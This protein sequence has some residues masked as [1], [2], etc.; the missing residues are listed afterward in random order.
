MARL[1]RKHIVASGEEGFYHVVNRVAGFP[2]YLPFKR[3]RVR[4]TLL[5]RLIKCLKIYCIDCFA[6]TIMGNHFHIVLRVNEF[7]KLTRRELER[8]ACE[9]WGDK[10][11]EVKTRHWDD[12]RWLRFNRDLFD[13]GSFM[14]HLESPFVAWYNKAFGREG[15]MWKSRY[16]SLHLKDLDA[17][18]ECL[19][20]VELN[21]VRAHL[22][23]RP[24]HWKE[25]SAVMRMNGEDELLIPLREVFPELPE[26]EPVLPHYRA[27]MLYRGLTTPKEGQGFIEEE[28]IRMEEARNFVDP[29]AYLTKL[30]FMTHGLVLGSSDQ[31]ANRLE[32]LLRLGVYK[33]KRNPPRQLRGRL[34]TLREQRS[35]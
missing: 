24:E 33:R 20:Y 32:R 25:G 26:N 30:R 28:I 21:P 9:R 6:F 18:Q 11:W 29:G 5:N 3:G 19:F 10:E 16:T 13:L 4:K 17:V 1:A 7:R 22:K 2:R 35:H 8:R 31:I 34:C 23:A 14:K 15:T 27:R 12:E